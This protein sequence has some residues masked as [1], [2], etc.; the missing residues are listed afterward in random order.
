MMHVGFVMFGVSLLALCVGVV[1]MLL[2]GGD[3]M[4]LQSV[5]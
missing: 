3:K 2:P 1:K 5:E 4:W